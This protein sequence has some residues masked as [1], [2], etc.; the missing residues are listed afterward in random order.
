[1]AKTAK[2]GEHK[3]FPFHTSQDATPYLNEITAEKGAVGYI[4]FNELYRLILGG[5]NGYFVEFNKK[6]L[7]ELN[8]RCAGCNLQLNQIEDVL[9][10]LLEIG[11]FD[12]DK[13][14]EFNVLTSKEL[15][16]MHLDA[17]ARR[18]ENYIYKEHFLLNEDDLSNLKRKRDCV[19]LGDKILFI[20][21]KENQY[22]DIK[23]I[24]V[25]NKGINV[26]NYGI[27]VDNNTINDNIFGQTRARTHT[28][29]LN[30]TK[31]N[32]TKEN[33]TFSDV[34]DN[35]DVTTA[36]VAGLDFQI[37][38][39]TYV[40]L[41]KNLI[42][43]DNIT[44]KEINKVILKLLEKNDREIM[45]EAVYSVIGTLMYAKEPIKDYRQYI[46]K[47]ITNAINV[48]NSRRLEEY[49]ANEEDELDKILSDIEND[50]N[51]FSPSSRLFNPNI[52]K[53][54]YKIN[55]DILSKYS[56][57]RALKLSDRLRELLNELEGDVK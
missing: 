14:V 57:E 34:I 40:L 27:N 33:K 30:N 35:V 9:N 1:M 18:T 55:L 28:S 52:A 51:E 17:G 45:N 32:N 5:N 24:N 20:D 42:P 41:S 13:Y 54:M 22:A 23:G 26:S 16:M 44:V 10:S 8:R 12:K 38:N 46:K 53:Q 15:Q 56:D 7:L 25:D 2:L 4:I 39:I 31:E 19:E 3:Y 37:D 50:I 11:A 48:I 21:K 43:S 6:A 47:A 49:K 36:T 29:I